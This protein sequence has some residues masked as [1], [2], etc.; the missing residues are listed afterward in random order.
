MH[1]ASKRM[2]AAVAVLLSA[3][4]LTRAA[5]KPTDQIFPNTTK[6]FVSATDTQALIEKWNETQL[7]MFGDDPLMQPFMDDLRDQIDEERKQDKIDWGIRWDDVRDLARGESAAAFIHVKGRRP[8]TAILVDV[9][10]NQDAAVAVLNKI[11]QSLHQQRSTW[12]QEKVANRNLTVFTLPRNPKDP[13]RPP[14]V[15]Y[16]LKNNFLAAVDDAAV[17]R[18]IMERLDAE[19]TD[20]LARVAIY[21]KVMQRC[22]ADAKLTDGDEPGARWY[23]QPLEYA[24]ARRVIDP[25]FFMS[26]KLDMIRVMRNSGFAA[27]QAMGG[28][29]HLRA[30]EYDTLNR[31]AVYAPPPYQ[32]SMKMLETPNDGPFPPYEW[33]PANVAGYTSGSW[34]LRTAV[35][36]IE[37]LYDQ[38][39]GNGDEG[40]WR[41]ALR[42][43]REDREGPQIDME[44]RLFPHLGSRLTRISDV[45]TP[46]TTQSERNLFVLEL[47]DAKAVETALEQYYAKDPLAT[48]KSAGE[49]PYWEIEPEDEEE[50]EAPR[51]RNPA[52]ATKQG[53]SEAEKAEPS[54]L[55]VAHDKLLIASHASL[56]RELLEGKGQGTLAEDPQYQQV[57]NLIKRE[58]EKRSWDKTCLWRFV[59][60]DVAYMPTYELTRMGKLPE[61]KS[62]VGEA[63]NMVLEPEA[64]SNTRKQQVDGS[65]LPAY[66]KVRHYLTPFGGV[67]IRDESQEFQGW[68]FVSFGLGKGEVE[69]AGE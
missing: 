63:L 33:I 59:R 7:G 5:N 36:N 1:L 18:Q 37:S 52:L 44:K 61:S 47:R 10:D 27:M 46:I 39:V 4:G 15:A 14:Q 66:D 30:G 2:A 54:G 12:K 57:S 40:V 55:A 29:I 65:K 6:A 23:V 19:A 64:G 28:Y 11:F 60:S 9:T 51:S 20:T 48:K 49:H 42:S 50:E 43:I 21:Q 69:R 67:G 13:H 8:A 32:K 35:N 24:E 41:D 31:M 45:K 3:V 17:A 25:E 53:A 22:A 68:F 62:I 26:D 58:I 34:D 38:T 56:L 16:F